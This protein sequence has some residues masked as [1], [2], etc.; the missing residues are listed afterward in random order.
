MKDCQL[1]TS[2]VVVT[3]APEIEPE[4]LLDVAEHDLINTGQ[5]FSPDNG[6]RDA[7]KEIK[8]FDLRTNLVLRPLSFGVT[9]IEERCR[10]PNEDAE[11]QDVYERE[12][13]ESCLGSTTKAARIAD[14]NGNLPPTSRLAVR[15]HKIAMRPN[16]EGNDLRR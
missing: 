2:R 11:G 10:G 7:M 3:D 13:G 12:Q 1:V 15:Q 16:T 8:S 5:V 6:S 14:A 9:A 4:M